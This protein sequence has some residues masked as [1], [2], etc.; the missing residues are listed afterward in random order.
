MITVRNGDKIKHRVTGLVGV[1]MGI[2]D[3]LFGCRR[4]HVQAFEL[5]DG[6]PQ[7]LIPFDEDEVEIISPGFILPTVAPKAPKLAK[8]TGGPR[9]YNVQK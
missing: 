3:W 4:V 8:A 2:T 7:D 6:R 1:V 5:K 9:K